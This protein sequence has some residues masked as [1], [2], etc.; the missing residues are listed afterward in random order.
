MFI[1]GKSVRAVLLLAACALAGCSAEPT[2][3][4][5]PYSPRHGHPYRFGYVATRECD[6]QMGRWESAHS[7]AAPMSDTLAYGGGVDGVGVTSGVPRVYLVFYGS[8]W[9]QGGGGE[10]ESAPAGKSGRAP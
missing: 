6:E 9:A 10:P 5:N 7:Y 4:E 3:Y 2:R 8:Q 1:S